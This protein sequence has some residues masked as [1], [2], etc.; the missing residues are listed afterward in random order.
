M[1]KMCG[2]SIYKP[3]EIIFRQ[4]LLNSVLPSE[5]K[6]GII[7]PFHKNSDKQNIKNYRQI[8]L[9]PIRG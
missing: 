9:L 6:K 8:S 5:W 2:D 4:V 7:V 1:L 3:R